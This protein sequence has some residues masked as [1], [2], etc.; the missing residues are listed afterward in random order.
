M[1]V[2]FEL[3]MPAVATSS[4]TWTGSRKKFYMIRTLNAKTDKEK[5][6]RLLNGNSFKSFTYNFGDGWVA[7]VDMQIVNSQ[8]AFIRKKISAGFYGY[9]WMVDSIIRRGEISAIF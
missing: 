4:G 8:E 9:E 2:S 3:T 6:S 1:K 5:V 7:K